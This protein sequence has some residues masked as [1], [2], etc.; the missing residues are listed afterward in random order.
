MERAWN[1]EARTDQDTP[2]DGPLLSAYHTTSLR[3]RRKL[4]VV[5]TQDLYREDQRSEGAETRFRNTRNHVLAD[6]VQVWEKTHLSDIYRHLS[7]AD[8]DGETVD[9]PSHNEHTDILRC[10]NDDGSN[11]PDDGANLDGALS[12]ENI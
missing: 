6:P 1:E 9:E 7:R 3:R 11:T 12:A 4:F 2:S 10:A 8:S 5:S